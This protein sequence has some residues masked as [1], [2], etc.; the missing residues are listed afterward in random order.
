MIHHNDHFIS[1]SMR[2]FVGS[3][4]LMSYHWLRKPK[5]FYSLSPLG[6]MSDHNWQ[7]FH[8]RGDLSFLAYTRHIFFASC[9]HATLLDVVPFIEPTQ[10]NT[11][12]SVDLPTM[13]LHQLN[14]MF[15]WSL[16][17]I[18]E[19]GEVIVLH[20]ALDRPCYYV[21]TCCILGR[22]PRTKETLSNFY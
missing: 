20:W 4:F 15:V 21:C 3:G 18:S 9:N 7:V 13:H 5:H 22:A 17:L 19:P 10:S 11:K 8:P 12:C 1:K 14:A 16:L 6:N 2:F